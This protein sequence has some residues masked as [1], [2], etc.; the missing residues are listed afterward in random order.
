VPLALIASALAGFAGATLI[1]A[2]AP[3]WRLAAPTWRLTIPGIPHPGNS[4]TSAAFFMAGLV[5]LWLGWLGLIGQAERL[6]GG[7]RRRRIAVI[8]VLA[9][10]CIPPLLG[11]PLLSNDSYSYAAQGEM[12]ARGI[13]PTASGPYALDRGQYLRA[14]DPVWRDAPAPYGPVSVQVAE[15]TA[16]GTGHDPNLSVWA[17]RGLALLGVVLSGVGIVSLARRRGHAI[18]PALAAGLA[19]PLVLIHMLGGSH[20]DTLMMGLLLVGLAAFD[21]G[22]KV[23]AV[24]LVVLAVGVKLPAAVALV[25][26]GWCWHHR[27]GFWARVRSTA[28]VGVASIGSLVALSVATGVGPGWITALGDTGKVTSTFSITTKLGFIAADLVGMGDSPGSM[29]AIWRLGGMVVAAGFTLWLLLRSP[30]RDMAR[31]VGLS[32][33]AF[34]LLGPVLW[35]W[36]L[37]A[38]LAV[39]AA[40]G[41]GRFR[42]SYLVLTIAASLFVWPASVN[43]VGALDDHQHLLGLLVVTSVIGACVAAQWVSPRLAAWRQRRSTGVVVTLD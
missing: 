32:M 26:M 16:I 8:A 30:E 4:G 34:I 5:L 3:V 19:G 43:A 29:V 9:L 35:P 42:P 23:L 20:N 6:P 28:L 40:T 31:A 12:A 22:R 2:S 37:P 7:D 18:A 39:V 1:V 24:G 33:L 25:F 13:D 15:W 10:W 38:G 17:W 36:Y 27:A 21:A 41:V 11:P 14:V